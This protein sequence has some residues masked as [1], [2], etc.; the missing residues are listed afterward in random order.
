MDLSVRSEHVSSNSACFNAEEMTLSLRNG[1]PL[2]AN[3]QVAG[4]T[5]LCLFADR[6]RAEEAIRRLKQEGFTDE[7]IGVVMQEPGQAS[8]ASNDE[9]SSE[10]APA[11]EGSL[12]NGLLGLLA[13]LLIPGLGP[14]L[15]GG[16]LA[17]KL[18]GAGTDAAAGGLTG[19]LVGLGVSHAA[20][21]HFEGGLR[22]EGILVTVN[23]AER[24]SE[25]VKLVQKY[26]ADL[27][28][29]NRRSGQ[30]S[31]GYAGPERRLVQV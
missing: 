22:N 9:S 20:A 25:V 17:S 10:V 19:I 15:L 23:A 31:D 24:T 3:A 16:V 7:E 4:I 30:N 8:S 14:L 21:E 11:V 6:P 13:S 18:S 28:P 1:E 27:G 29:R 2:P 5:V 12:T 26:G